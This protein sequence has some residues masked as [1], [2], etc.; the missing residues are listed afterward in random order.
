[1]RIDGQLV[2]VRPRSRSASTSSHGPW[3]IA[4]IGFPCSAKSL[5]SWIDSDV[6]SQMIGIAHAAGQDQ[7]VEVVGMGLID[8]QVR[9]DRLAR[10]VVDRRL[11]RIALGRREHDLGAALLENLA[12]P[13]QLPFLEAVGRD[14]QDSR[15]RNQR[16]WAPPSQS[17]ELARLPLAYARSMGRVKRNTPC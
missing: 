14:D 9:A 6:H 13:E 16:H 1:M 15:I 2:A 5:I 17:Q 4:P 8:R 12:R 7:R 11:D 3:Q 10:I